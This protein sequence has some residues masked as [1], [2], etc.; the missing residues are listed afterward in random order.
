M[1]IVKVCAHVK[2]N[3][4]ITNFES[5]SKLGTGTRQDG[6]CSQ[7]TTKCEDIRLKLKNECLKVYISFEKSKTFSSTLKYLISLSL[8]L[9]AEN[10]GER[11]NVSYHHVSNLKP[12]TLSK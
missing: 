1:Y 11:P 12:F 6:T 4:S 7:Y 8:L 5:G 10:E 9:F 3:F 2:R